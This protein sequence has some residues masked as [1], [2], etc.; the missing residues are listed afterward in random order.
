MWPRAR[1]CH[2]IR[3]TEIGNLADQ[4]GRI[5]GPSIIKGITGFGNKRGGNTN[6]GVVPG[7]NQPAPTLVPE[8][9]LEFLE[10]T[11]PSTETSE[12]NLPE[13]VDPTDAY[14]DA[15]NEFLY[16]PNYFPEV[17]QY[18]KKPVKT[19]AQTFNRDYF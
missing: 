15:L 4:S 16:N 11:I 8:E 17:Q 19:F 1:S 18:Q 10:P 5:T 6:Q 7:A 3:F 14:N 13:F 2:Q 12:I 9:I